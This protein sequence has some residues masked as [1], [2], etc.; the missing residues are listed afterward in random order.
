MSSKAKKLVKGS[1]LRTIGFVVNVVGG[2]VLMP[3][4]VSTLGDKQYGFWV[5]IGTFIGY[6]GLLDFGIM[7]AVQRF[8]SRAVGA[9]DTQDANT[10]VNTSLA[11]YIII[12]VFVLLISGIVVLLA[13]VFIKDKN[14]LHI[15]RLIIPLLSLSLAIGFPMRVFKGMLIAH[16]RFDLNAIAEIISNILRIALVLVL[17]KRGEGILILA[18]VT[19]LTQVVMHVLTIIFAKVTIKEMRLSFKLVKKSKIKDIFNYSWITVVI[20]IATMVRFRVSAF[21]IAAS[22][23]LKEVTIYS[24]S[25]RLIE[26]YNEAMRSS[27]GIFLPVFSQYEGKDDYDSLRKQYVFISKIAGYLGLLIGCTLVLF[28][29]E[30]IRR[31]MGEAYGQ[32]YS[33]MIIL[34]VA[35]V[36]ASMQI[37]SAGMLYGI[38]KHKFYIP[39]N[40]AEALVNVVLSVVLVRY[41]GLYG[42]ALGVSIPLFIVKLFVEPIYVCKVIK[43]N[44][45]E[46]YIKTVFPV[47]IFAVGF[48]FG[49][50]YLFSNFIEPDYVS[51]VVMASVEVILFSIMVYFLGFTRA[52]RNYIWKSIRH[53]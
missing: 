49:F 23:G 13:P 33:L 35:N 36:F 38:S 25:L 7:Q 39:A 31:W 34:V 2:L 27:M 19:F 47:I 26:Y 50:R 1:M 40:V 53:K 52:E 24:I 51:L 8:V 17:L 22:L 46:Y 28:G 4:I 3:F 9:D 48:I 41:Y 43:L 45:K 37:I 21:I 18:L 30:F 32:S 11:L 12:G 6:Y 15:F 20:A 42:I 14:N 16:L 10:V 29:S 5:L 44:I